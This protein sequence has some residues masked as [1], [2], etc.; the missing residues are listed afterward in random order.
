M[1]ADDTKVSSTVEIESNIQ[2]LQK[3]ID[4]LV[5]W[6]D[7]WQ[8]R[9][10]S[11]KCKVIHLGRN[12]PSHEYTM[13]LHHSHERKVLDTSKL[14][15]DLGVLIDEELNFSK[16][17]EAQV[18]KANRI[19]GLI[20]RSYRFLDGESL[21]YMFTSLVRPHLEF[22][23]VVW[24]PR[25]QKDKN[26]IEGV[27]R[28]AT[29]LVPGMTALPYEE[30]LRKL[31]LPSMQYRRDRGD[32]IE[33]YKFTH[34][35]Y[36]ARSPLTPENDTRTRGHMYKLKKLRV[37]KGIRQGFFPIRITDIW[38][39]LPADIVNA[40]LLNSFKNRLD[41]YWNDRLYRA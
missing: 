14:E 3:D 8:L 6:A 41:K 33:V 13:R 4:R 31:N 7:K 40:P 11:D 20:R 10:N 36:D 9:F 12:N 35:L 16:H 23:N 2:D 21:R 1:Y 17:I 19:L 27:L 30:R 18:A 5:D 38:N 39:G 15:K 25:Y 29:K 22:A 24:S 32:M 26:L 37:N 28:R 34:D